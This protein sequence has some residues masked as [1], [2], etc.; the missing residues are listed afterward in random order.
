[1]EH[2]NSSILLHVFCDY[3]YKLCLLHQYF[4]TSST[5]YCPK[6]VFPYRLLRYILL[7]IEY[8][9]SWQQHTQ[10]YFTLQPLNKNIQ[11]VIF[12]HN[13]S[14]LLVEYSSFQWR[15]SE[16]T[17]YSSYSSYSSILFFKMVV[18]WKNTKNHFPLRLN[19]LH[20]G[21][22][23]NLVPFVCL[24]MGDSHFDLEVSNL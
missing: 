1:M 3:Y 23:L 13:F 21:Y 12:Y 22:K 6:V 8:P 2:F 5:Y 14:F 17:C 15:G 4:Q 9:Y 19:Q 20:Y 7:Y 24:V 10:W 18:L 11:K 16:N